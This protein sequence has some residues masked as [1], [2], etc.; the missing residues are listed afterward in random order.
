M[1]LVACS[2]IL[3]AHVRH[4][5]ASDA[6]A[7]SSLSGGRHLTFDALRNTRGP[8]L[9]AYD[10]GQRLRTG[11][12]LFYRDWLETSGEARPPAGPHFDK[13]AC[14]DCHLE[15]ARVTV[16]DLSAPLI[17]KPATLAQARRYGDQISTD[18]YDSI[19]PEAVLHV[20]HVFE[21]FAYPDGDQRSLTRPV[22]TILDNDRG[23]TPVKLR[24]P[25][26]LFGWGLLERVDA[27]MI[28]HFDDPH[29][30]N[31]DGI[32]GRLVIAGADDDA[33]VAR[34]AI[35]GW[36]NS[37]GTLRDQ[38]AAA[39]ANDMGVDSA[40]VCGDAC[41]AEIS[42]LE[43]DAL[44]EYVRYLGVPRRRGSGHSR[45]Q[46]LF[47]MAGCSDCHVPVLITGPGDDPALSEQVIWAYS[48]LML[49]DMGPDLADPGQGRDN[50]EWRTAPLWGV[51]I[52]ESRLPERGF[53]HDG[54]AAN[55]EEA[56]LWHGG[57]AERSRRYFSELS[58]EDRAALLAYLRSL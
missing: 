32:S 44:T 21:T 37:H 49:H 42:S 30:R 48:D 12:S 35:F 7:I 47:G 17:A 10:P 52:V 34:P 26:L 29:D 9:T 45:G 24:A 18:G 22:G 20:E 33:S 38:I 25:P 8:L 2:G 4:T 1:A 39:L 23:A 57:E 3:A 13:T 56:I 31:R 14:A 41:E 15:T 5:P 6:V 53:L 54:R 36:K 19:G 27:S 28:A 46:D 16:S 11:E 55:L 58:R 40:H 51:G 43:L 50:R